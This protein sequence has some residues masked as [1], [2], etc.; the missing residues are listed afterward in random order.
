MNKP[1]LTKIVTQIK[2]AEDNGLLACAFS[3]EEAKEMRDL[4]TTGYAMRTTAIVD[5]DF[6]EA[7]HNFDTRLL[8][9]MGR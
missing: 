5:D 6:P 8:R 7:A 1:L 9:A 4:I 2:A 3:I